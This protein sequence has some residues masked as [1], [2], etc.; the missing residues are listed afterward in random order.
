M[1]VMRE[2][3][4]KPRET[5][6]VHVWIRRHRL[7]TNAADRLGDYLKEPLGRPNQTWSDVTPA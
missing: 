7:R 6:P 3:D 1:I 4:S 5:A 2:H